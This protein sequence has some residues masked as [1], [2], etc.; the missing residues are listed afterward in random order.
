MTGEPPGRP[1]TVVGIGADGW[2][3]LC[4]AARDAVST[5]QVVLGS[6]RQLELVGDQPGELREWPSPMLPAL[7]ALFEAMAGRRVCALASG[8]PM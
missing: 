7:P 1:V 8:D 6:R 5:A 2:R 3:G 4:A